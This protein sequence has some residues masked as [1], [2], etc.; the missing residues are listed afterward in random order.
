[1]CPASSK[2]RGPANPGGLATISSL[3][4]G[5]GKG[6]QNAMLAV[7]VRGNP[8]YSWK[9]TGG[10]H[11]GGML[12]HANLALST[13]YLSVHAP[14]ECR[15]FD[16]W[17]AGPGRYGASS[18]D[19]VRPLRQTERRPPGGLGNG[20]RLPFPGHAAGIVLSPVEIAALPPRRGVVGN[21]LGQGADREEGHCYQEY[22]EQPGARHGRGRLGP[23]GAFGH[24]FIMHKAPIGH[25][26]RSEAY[27]EARPPGRAVRTASPPRRGP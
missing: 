6:K 25:R 4:R 22:K 24:L 3:T 16:R 9:V 1:M 26:Q 10:P 13:Q 18:A 21:P 14:R 11:P 12:H 20:D 15:R 27:P 5:A 19:R 23:R 17:R 2:E 8:A 7:S